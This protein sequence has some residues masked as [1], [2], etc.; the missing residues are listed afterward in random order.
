MVDILTRVRAKEKELQEKAITKW[1]S[2]RGVFD[3]EIKYVSRLQFQKAMDR[4]KKIVWTQKHER[5]EELNDE[6]VKDFLKDCIVSWEGLTVEKF[7]K[8]LF[9][10]TFSNKEANQ[11]IPCDED[12]KEAIL[13]HV[14]GIV[15]FLITEILSLANVE[16][17][18]TET[19][20]KNS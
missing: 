5:A 20:I 15:N 1:V 17:K 9:P 6:K 16:E 11:P 3:I 10:I 8:E 13:E 14:Y 12:A 2:F 19:Q 4:C 18:E 7:A